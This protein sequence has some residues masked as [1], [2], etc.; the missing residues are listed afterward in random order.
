MSQALT[1]AQFPVP[2]ATGSIEAY[3]SAANRVPMLT[4]EEEKEPRPSF[5]RRG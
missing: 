3:I 1:L 4:E 2:S 5:S